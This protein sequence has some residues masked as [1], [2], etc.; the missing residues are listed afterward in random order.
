MHFTED[1]FK[2]IKSFHVTTKL[3]V[4]IFDSQNQKIKAYYSGVPDIFKYDL[5]HWE[6]D[7]VP[8][9]FD[10]GVLHE[11][12]LSMKY[13]QGTI[14][15]GPW[16]TRPVSDESI[17][18]LVENIRTSQ[19]MNINEATCRTYYDKLPIYPLGDIRDIIIILSYLFNTDMNSYYSQMLHQE[20]QQN[21]LKL[22][23]SEFQSFD[24]SRFATERYAYHYESRILSLVGKGDLD[25]LKKGLSDIGG[26]VCPKIAG[27]TIRS[28]KNYTIM[29]MEKLSTFAINSGKDILKTLQIR[30]FYIKEVEEQN[31]LVDV[32][33]VR[34]CGI[35]HFTH[36]IHDLINTSLSPTV[37]S[38]VQ[39][40]SL[41][42][43]E[44]LRVNEL[45]RKLYISES[46]L[47]RLFKSEM[48]MTISEY[49]NRRRITEAKIFLLEG[50]SPNAV[51]KKFGFFDTSHFGRMFK[52]YED[53]TPRQFIDANYH[54]QTFDD[55]NV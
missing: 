24:E 9:R 30:D 37:F 15:V 12:F 10:E 3:A 22:Q 20:V 25:L 53:M 52:K 17:K 46:R 13:R 8:L 11:T 7:A 38:A 45:A 41:Y 49:M 42:I 29:M 35:I 6:N 51:S 2:K 44:P 36:A 43:Y 1:D 34:D 40:I 26:S 4:R 48:N 23:K 50:W 31:T 14:V 16:L 5:P 39:M 21:H 28:E 27:D 32:L 47:R 55:I 33:T 19:N 54:N 18:N